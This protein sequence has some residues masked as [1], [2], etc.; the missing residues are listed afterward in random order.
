M[1]LEF[2]T[3]FRLITG[4]FDEYYGIKPYAVLDI[5]QRVAGD[6]ADKLGIGTLYCEEHNYAWILARQEVYIY[7]NPN[8]TE[9]VIVRTFPHSPSKIEFKRED[10]P[11]FGR[12][13][14]AI[15]IVLSSSISSLTSKSAVISSNKSPTPPEP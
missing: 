1:K 11:A 8:P 14:I 4:M 9:T 7:N 13:T 5:F 12:P 6:H 15:L 10:F 3:Q 2:E